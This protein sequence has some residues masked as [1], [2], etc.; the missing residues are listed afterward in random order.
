[1]VKDYGDNIYNG[2]EPDSEWRENVNIARD[3]ISHNLVINSKATLK[4]M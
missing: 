2:L 3:E 4:L 1:M